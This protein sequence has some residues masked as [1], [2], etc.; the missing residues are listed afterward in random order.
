M[1]DGDEVP[2]APKV[3]IAGAAGAAIAAALAKMA[4]HCG[5]LRMVLDK[6]RV[7]A[8]GYVFTISFT[9]PPGRPVQR[10]QR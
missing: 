10:R 7:A 3:P 2:G 4:T 9:Q 8:G 5:E 6:E 1:R